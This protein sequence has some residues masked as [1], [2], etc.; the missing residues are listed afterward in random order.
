MRS[1][2]RKQQQQ[3]SGG[4][5]STNIQAGRDAIVHIGITAAE[6]KDIALEVIREN[7]ITS[8]DATRSGRLAYEQLLASMLL[9]AVN[10]ANE[11]KRADPDSSTDHSAY[12]LRIV[13]QAND[14]DLAANRPVRFRWEPA[15]SDTYRVWPMIIGHDDRAVGIEILYFQKKAGN[16]R[17][18]ETLRQIEEEVE[19]MRAEGASFKVLVVSNM[20]MPQVGVVYTENFDAFGGNA[21]VANKA[22][23]PALVGAIGRA[24]E[25]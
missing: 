1:L 22:D 12:P 3:Q 25:T 21:A 17:I 5:G 2:R 11:E 20:R 14:S 15:R 16:L 6:T 4:T 8:R 23:F 7:A 10:R 18:L 9:E 19:P 13:L 24:F